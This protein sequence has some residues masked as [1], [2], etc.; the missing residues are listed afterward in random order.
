MGLT[1]KDS[2]FLLSR[3]RL[4]IVGAAHEPPESVPY[5]TARISRYRQK[6][7]WRIKVY[8]SLVMMVVLYMKVGLH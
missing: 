6:I 2:P 1:Q 7:L 5:K 8:T 4:R 3:P